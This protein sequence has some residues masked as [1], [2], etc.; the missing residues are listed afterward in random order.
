MES[1]MKM[2][3]PVGAYEEL[4]GI[5]ELYGLRKE[6]IKIRDAYSAEQMKQYGR[7]LLEEALK[8]AHP[9]DSYQDQWYE[10]KVDV[11]KRIL[12]LKETL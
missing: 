8:A 5:E 1:S 2:P 12:K 9:E 4:V 3:E 11:Y 6:I 10:A 7:D